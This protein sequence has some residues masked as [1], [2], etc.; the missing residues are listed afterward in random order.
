MITSKKVEH[1]LSWR[2]S[3]MQAGTHTVNKLANSEQP[4]VNPSTKP[5]TKTQDDEQGE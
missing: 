4:I 2:K 3:T 5:I 1:F